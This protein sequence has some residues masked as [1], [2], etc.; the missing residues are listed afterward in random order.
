MIGDDVDCKVAEVGY[1]IGQAHWG[2]GIATEALR[3][4]SRYAFET[5]DLVRLQAPVFE[6]NR[7]SARVAEKAGYKLEG[8]LRE[9]VFKNGRV[10]DS[11]MYALLWDEL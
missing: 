9:S 1:W 8:R 10:A 5:F 11:F 4:L 2:K 7:A 3:C 6:W